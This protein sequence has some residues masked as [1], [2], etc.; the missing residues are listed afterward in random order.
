MIADAAALTLV[1]VAVEV[2][3]VLVNSKDSLQ[4]CLLVL[5]FAG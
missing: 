5:V 3:A 4:N 1:A 2:V